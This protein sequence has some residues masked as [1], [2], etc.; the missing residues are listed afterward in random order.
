MKEKFRYTSTWAIILAAMC[1]L[2]YY[3]KEYI[4]HN[5]LLFSKEDSFII[6]IIFILILIVLII[7]GYLSY[8]IHEIKK[9]IDEMAEEMST[10]EG[11][12]SETNCTQFIHIMDMLNKISGR[13]VSYEKKSNVESDEEMD[14]KK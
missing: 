3:S 7:L 11:N 1:I 9:A 5:E 12:I 13:K 8:Q 14:R 10:I 2:I 6:S 4:S